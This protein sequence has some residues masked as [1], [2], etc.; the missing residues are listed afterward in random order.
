MLTVL[1]VLLVAPSVRAQAV[2][3]R[4]L[5]KL[6]VQEIQ[7]EGGAWLLRVRF[8]IPVRYVRH[9]PLERGDLLVID[10]APLAVP[11]DDLVPALR[12]ESLNVPASSDLGLS[13]LSYEGDGLAPNLVL[14][15]EGERAF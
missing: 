14:R 11:D 4:I 1:S 12:R 13:E 9:S 10:L 3:V 15:F 6:E 2:R 5:D 7:D 8:A